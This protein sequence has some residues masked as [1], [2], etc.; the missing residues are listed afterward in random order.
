MRNK[1]S[2]LY[3]YTLTYP[4]LLLYTLFFVVPVAAGIVMAFTDWQS[5]RILEPAFNGL[6][7]FRALFNDERFMKSLTNT[8]WFASITMILKVVFGLPLAVALDKP[9]KTRGYL[10]TIF[11]FPG[12][13][14]AVVIGIMFTSLFQMD[15]VVDRFLNFFGIP[16]GVN[17]LGQGNTAMAVVMLT[18][19]WQWT[20]LTMIIFLAGLQG[21]PGDYYEAS[22]ID[23][24][25]A[26]RQFRHITLPLLAPSFTIIFT[27]SLIGGLK[28]FANVYVL[29][30]GGPGFSTQVLATYIYQAFGSGLLGLSSAMGL[31]LTV[32]VTVLTLLLNGYLRRKELEL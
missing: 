11:F 12:I 21:I 27:L 8:L 26:Y 28:V 23:G 24:A 25:S 17:W 5:T 9:L 31:V 32:L 15:G 30:N 13:L 2:S 18:D 4:A 29:T 7:N 14:S 20:G 10:R 16:T 22:T 6:D 3:S 19:V 1:T